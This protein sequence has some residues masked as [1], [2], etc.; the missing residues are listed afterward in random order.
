MYLDNKIITLYSQYAQKNNGTYNSDVTFNFNNILSEDETFIRAYVSVMN[1]QIPSSF[2]IIN[3]TN[4]VFN[5]AYINMSTILSITLKKGNYNATNLITEMQSKLTLAGTPMTITIDKITGNLT[6]TA[7]STNFAIYSNALSS[8][9]GLFAEID[10]FTTTNITA[11]L[12]VITASYPLNLLGVKQLLIKSSALCISSFDSRTLG[13]NDAITSIPCNSAPFGLILYESKSDL[14]K[15][16]LVS[17]SIEQIDIRISDE[18]DNLINFN[19]V[20]W[21]ISICLSVERKSPPEN[22][23]I[24]LI[25]YVNSLVEKEPEKAKVKEPVDEELQLLESN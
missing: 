19:N 24:E 9:L 17:G 3:E 11:F 21:S 10:K 12:G 20:N 15:H 7:L 18:H 14:D 4:N 23:N 1:A 6:F 16:L 8:L 5:Y 2:Y 13:L 25:P 22:P